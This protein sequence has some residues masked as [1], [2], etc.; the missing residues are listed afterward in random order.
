MIAT[1]IDVVLLQTTLSSYFRLNILHYV[2]PNCLSDTRCPT[3]LASFL[4]GP[5][6]S[7]PVRAAT[8]LY[9]K[10]TE[11]TLFLVSPATHWMS[12]LRMLL[13]AIVCPIG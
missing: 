3:L 5:S 1:I 9:V 4:L 12:M 8:V 2:T 10:P 7:R 11:N 6:L 13:N